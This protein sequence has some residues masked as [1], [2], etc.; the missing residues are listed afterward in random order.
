MCAQSHADDCVVSDERFDESELLLPKLL[1]VG[2]D[3]QAIEVALRS[4]TECRRQRYSAHQ[5]LTVLAVQTCIRVDADRRISTVPRPGPR[6]STAAGRLK[7]HKKG[8]G[9]C[10]FLAFSL[11]LGKLKHAYRW[12]CLCVLDRREASLISLRR[13]LN[14]VQRLDAVF[15]ILLQ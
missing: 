13:P 11:Q 3:G 14:G 10:S 5:V 4:Y 8:R 7:S 6:V 1:P 2:V 9:V 15:C 12:M